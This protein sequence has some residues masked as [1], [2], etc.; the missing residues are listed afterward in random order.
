LNEGFDGT[1]R[2]IG[3]AHIIGVDADAV[4]PFRFIP[5]FPDLPMEE[6]YQRE[7]PDRPAVICTENAQGGRT[8]YFPFDLGA[9][10]WEALQSDHGRLIANAVSWALGKAPEVTV[11]GPG[12]VDVAVHRGENEVAVALVNL[13]NPMAMRGAIRETLPLPPQ[14]VSI[15]VPTDNLNARLLVAGVDVEPVIR[16]GRA[17]IAI[18][19]AGLLEVVHLDWRQ[20]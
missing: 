16:D 13:T 20:A 8:V 2:I 3:G 17:E 12:L 10:F 6:V 1:T 5:D 19:T 14:T 15:A 7:A 4:T 11:D 18:P 9:I